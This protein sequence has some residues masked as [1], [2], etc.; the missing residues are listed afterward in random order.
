MR[1][2]GHSARPL[3]APKSLEIRPF[4]ELRG[5]LRDTGGVPDQFSFAI[6]DSTGSELPT[7]SI[8]DVFLEIDI[9]SSKPPVQT[10][11]S[12]ASQSPVAGG[13]P[14]DIVAPTATPTGVGSIPEPST[15]AMMAIGVIGLLGLAS[16]RRSR[17][18]SAQPFNA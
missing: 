15:S 8:F 9:N 2:F 5:F 18:A 3:S 1:I 4:S 13:P 16:Y 17:K 6:L 12:D 14:I 7:L 11:A 10:F